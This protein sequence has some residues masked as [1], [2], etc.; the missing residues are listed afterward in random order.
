MT[1]QEAIKSGK[2]FRPTGD[3]TEGF[4]NW[5]IVDGGLDIGHRFLILGTPAPFYVSPSFIM[6]DFEIKEVA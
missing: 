6:K 1:I 3:G 2:P 4:Q 5:L